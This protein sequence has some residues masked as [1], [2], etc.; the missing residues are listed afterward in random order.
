MRGRMS[1]LFHCLVD[2]W[3]ACEELKPRTKENLVFLD[4]TWM[5]RHVA[6]SGVRPHEQIP[7]H[8]VREEQ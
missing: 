2:E 7:L 8:E 3:H 6:W 4:K 1:W 5:L